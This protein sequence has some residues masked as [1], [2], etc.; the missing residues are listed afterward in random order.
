MHEELV[1]RLW[2]NVGSVIEEADDIHEGTDVAVVRSEK[3]NPIVS[4]I[5]AE[6]SS[7]KGASVTQHV[8][9]SFDEWRDDLTLPDPLHSAIRNCDVLVSHPYLSAAQF[10]WSK[11]VF[12]A[13]MDH[14]VN[15]ISFSPSAQVLAGPVLEWPHELAVT[16]AGTLADRLF[17]A[18]RE[19]HI[20]DERGT[21]LRLVGARELTHPTPPS[22]LQA[23][24]PALGPDESPWGNL[25]RI[26]PTGEIGWHPFDSA[27]GTFVVDGMDGYGVLD[28]P[29]TWHI[30]DGALIDVTGGRIAQHFSRMIERH[31]TPN[32]KHYLA[33][34]SFGF[35]PKCT[36]DPTRRGLAGL[37]PMAGTFHVAMGISTNKAIPPAANHTHIDALNKSPTV[38]IDGEVIMEDGTLSLLDELRQNDQ[39]RAVAEKYGDADELLSEGS[40]DW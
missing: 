5:A 8:Y 37:L 10:Q 19:F 16:V 39:V 34:A 25:L 18:D 15:H 17:G 28:E 38:T 27:E 1:H 36:W 11:T 29:I 21:D 33:E 23:D 26:Y 9:P 24:Q 14:G 2:V 30:E 20:T 40:T 32:S 22:Q 13:M 35:N 7:A 6:A 31:A 12:G 4:Q 3:A